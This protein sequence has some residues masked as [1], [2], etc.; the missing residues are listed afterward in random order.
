MLILPAK[1]P[2][3]LLFILIRNGIEDYPNHKKDRLE[4]KRSEKQQRGVFPLF[5]GFLEKRWITPRKHP[6][7][8]TRYGL[9]G[10]SRC[11]AFT[12]CS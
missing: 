11:V 1:L 10:F 3:F 7:Y 6:P 2:S 12:D 4:K 5:F 9:V 8:S